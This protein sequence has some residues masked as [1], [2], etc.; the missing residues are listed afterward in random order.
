MDIWSVFSA[1]AP[2]YL[3]VGVGAWLRRAEWLTHEADE[4]L[5][6]VVVNVLTPCLIL[7][8]VMANEALRRPGNVLLPPLMGFVGAAIGLWVAGRVARGSG[9]RTEAERRTFVATAGFQNYG[10][11]PLPL[12]T[13]LFPKETTGVLFL[14]NLGVDVALWTL[15]LVAFGHAGWREWR[16]LLNPPLVAVVAGVL[17]N[18]CGL[19]PPGFVG[20][21]MHM[22]GVS[23]FPLGLVLIGATLSET[24][25]Q[26]RTGGG[27]RLMAAACV[28]RCALAP[29][30]MLLAAR[31]LPAPVE[32]QRV[33]VVEAAMP[34]AVFPIVMARH[35]G[36]DVLTS[37]RVVVATSILGFVTIPLWV[38]LGMAFIPG[39]SGVPIGP[40]VP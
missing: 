15:G 18:L 3:L 10:Y 14:H 26:L 31:W 25:P 17:L 36:G 1:V 7:D 32:L 8:N 13:A 12:I 4:S 22:L 28:A 21:A 33:L 29:A 24:T 23:C 11:A 16:K 2:V 5:L 40:G 34:A 37:V 20:S 19:R 6:R 38:R 30:V 27:A 9:A 39:V 35:Y